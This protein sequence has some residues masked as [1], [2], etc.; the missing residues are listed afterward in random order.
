MGLRIG[1]GTSNEVMAMAL[2]CTKQIFEA[3]DG[4]HFPA[5]KDD[6]LDLAELKDASEAVIVVLNGLREDVIYRDMS[7]ICE[8]ARITCGHNLVTWM[9]AAPFPAK[10]G[11]LMEFANRVGAPVSVKD[12]LFALPDGYTFGSLDEMCEYVL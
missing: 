2:Y 9:E 3:L 4:L 1:N 7:E 10:R 8:N 11:G 12:A 6:I 5:T